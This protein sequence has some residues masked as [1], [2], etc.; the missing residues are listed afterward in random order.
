[1]ELRPPSDYTTPLARSNTDRIR[2]V[3]HQGTGSTLAFVGMTP[4]PRVLVADVPISFIPDVLSQIVT[5]GDVL[6]ISD[7]PQVLVVVGDR[8]D[9]SLSADATVG[10]TRW[11][12]R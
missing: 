2:S 5:S 12:L 11:R 6:E 7:G 9:P 8:A 1:A 4:G 10:A 3:P